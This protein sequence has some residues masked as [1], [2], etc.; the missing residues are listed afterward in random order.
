MRKSTQ[1]VQ[2]NKRSRPATGTELLVS[3]RMSRALISDIDLWA[4]GEERQTWMARLLKGPREF[5]ELRQ[6][7]PQ[8]M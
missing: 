6:D 3:F 1:R 2:P 4:T 5:C 7:H 8:K